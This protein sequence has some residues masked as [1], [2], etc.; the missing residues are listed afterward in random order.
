MLLSAILESKDPVIFMEPKILYRAA[1]EE[2]PNEIYTL[3]LGKAE[4]LQPG[5]DLTI[6]SYGRPLY[7]CQQAIEAA[8][9][10]RPDVSIELID[11]RSIYPW[12]RETVLD[13]VRKTGRAIV[14]HESMVNYGVGSEIAATIQENILFHLKTPVRRLGGWTTHTGLSYEKYIFPDVAS[15]LLHLL[16]QSQYSHANSSPQ[17]CMITFFRVSRTSDIEDEQQSKI[18]HQNYDGTISRAH[19]YRSEL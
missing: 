17:E 3:P 18:K 4:I 2:V 14:V 1:I 16:N 8:K 11:L 12:D 10:D 6:I 13:S 19:T 5:N 7:T 15:M 9:N